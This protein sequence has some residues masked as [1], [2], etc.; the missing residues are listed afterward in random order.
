MAHTGPL[1]VDFKQDDKDGLHEF[2]TINAAP[3]AAG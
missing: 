2:G 3:T 1:P